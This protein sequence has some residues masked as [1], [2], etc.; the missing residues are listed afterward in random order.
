MKFINF[1]VES[2]FNFYYLEKTFSK[3]LNEYEGIALINF[4]SDI[5][6]NL[7]FLKIIN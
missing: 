7:F 3:F 5:W 6:L 2:I 4:I 1:K